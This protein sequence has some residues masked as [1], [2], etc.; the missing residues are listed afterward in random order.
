MMKIFVTHNRGHF[1][2][3]I[4]LTT[5]HPGARP[6]LSYVGNPGEKLYIATLTSVGT[7]G[8][9]LDLITIDKALYD[10]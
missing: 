3:T 6:Y 8:N 10:V 9:T 5:D 2:H 1:C 7:C 4:P